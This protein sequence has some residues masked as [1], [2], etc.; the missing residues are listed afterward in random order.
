[1]CEPNVPG[2][3]S[4]SCQVAIGN[5]F[6]KLATSSWPSVAGCC[7]FLTCKKQPNVHSKIRRIIFVALVKCKGLTLYMLKVDEDTVYMW[8]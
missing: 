8:F 7:N 6:E 5:Y 2:F 3:E 4:N 1:M